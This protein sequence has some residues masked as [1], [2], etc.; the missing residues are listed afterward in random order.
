MFCP[1]CGTPT[2]ALAARC[3]SCGR[4]LRVT[5]APIVGVLTPPP[6]SFGHGPPPPYDLPVTS[7]GSDVAT[8]AGSTS[9]PG[10]GGPGAFFAGRSIAGRYHIIRLLG[11]GGMG[12]VYQAWD[13]KLG[14][15]V[16]LKV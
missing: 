16:A 11:T 7:D 3:A 10:Q 14:V 2:D 15:A 4:A 6:T 8:Q 13:E 12:A 5:G 9:H 1:H